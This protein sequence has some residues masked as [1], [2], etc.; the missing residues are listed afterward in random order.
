MKKLEQL[1]ESLLWESR[2][3]VAAVVAS[4]LSGVAMFYMAT[5]DAWYM[6]VHPPGG[7]RRHCSSPSVQ[8]CARPR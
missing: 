3:V 4:L 1:F 6:L 2:L 8:L 5:V 7:L